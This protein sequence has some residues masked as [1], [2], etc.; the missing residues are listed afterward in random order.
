MNKILSEASNDNQY[1]TKL[2]DN[3]NLYLC[4]EPGPLREGTNIHF[5]FI[6][7][8]VYKSFYWQGQE[9]HIYSETSNGKPC[10]SLFIK[11]IWFN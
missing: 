9:K 4:H 10:L 1:I 2:G 7:L 5:E 11:I 6:V 8:S 3:G